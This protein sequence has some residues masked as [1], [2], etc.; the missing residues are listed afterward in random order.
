MEAANC[1]A[2]ISHQRTHTEHAKIT[3]G[4]GREGEGGR[5]GEEGKRSRA[6]THPRPDNRNKGRWIPQR[7]HKAPPHIS[8]AQDCS[9]SIPLSSF[10][11]SIL[12][13]VLYF[14]LTLLLSLSVVW[15]LCSISVQPFSSRSHRSRFVRCCHIAAAVNAK[16]ICTGPHKTAQ[17]SAVRS[18][19]STVIESLPTAETCWTR[20]IDDISWL[21]YQPAR[22]HCALHSLSVLCSLPHFNIWETFYSIDCKLLRHFY[23]TKI[24]FKNS[25]QTSSSIKFKL[26]AIFWRILPVAKSAL[27]SLSKAM[28]ASWSSST[29]LPVAAAAEVSQPSATLSLTIEAVAVA[30]LLLLRRRALWE[31]D[32]D[33]S[34]TARSKTSRSQ[35]SRSAAVSP[36]AF[37]A[38]RR[39]R[40]RRRRGNF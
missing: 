37:G 25:L 23:K 5:E 24:Q 10:P 36:S 27:I 18:V 39:R 3:R 12:S 22:N 40:R 6:L 4:K 34:S 28:A 29:L 8:L 35:R 30:S 1:S 19:I 20:L 32:D 16:P 17:V 31:D 2:V 26:T 15:E 33:V 13:R 7:S 21:W 11:F 38:K 14:S 9:P